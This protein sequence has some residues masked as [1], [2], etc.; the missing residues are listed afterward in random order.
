MLFNSYDFLLVFLPVAWIGW[1]LMRRFAGYLP[2]LAWLAFVS[3]AFYGYWSIDALV[4]MLASLSINCAIGRFIFD[5]RERSNEPTPEMRLLVALGIAG[6]LAL[7]GYFKYMGFFVANLNAATGLGLD[8]GAIVLPIGIS[9]YT[10]QQIAWLVDLYRGHAEKPDLLRHVLF[11][12]F[13]PH[14]I[15]GPITH[16]GEM[17][18]QFART[19]PGDKVEGM[20][21]GVTIGLTMFAIGL[22][23]KVIIA[24][25]IARVS[26]PIFLAAD[27]G[28]DIGLIE[29]WL[30]AIA[31][32]L[33]IYFDFSGYSDMAIG[34]A[35]MF[36]IILPLNFNSPYKA[37]SISDFWRRWH[38][39]L[40]R[41]LRDYVY[42]P[43]GGNR[44]GEWSKGRNLL[45]TM[46]LGGL[47][48]GA[49]WNFVIWGGLHGV[50]LIINQFWSKLTGRSKVFGPA[51]PVAR[52]AGQALTLLAVV[53]AWVFFRAGTLDGAFSILAGMAG[54]HGLPSPHAAIASLKE[55]K[56]ALLLLMALGAGIALFLPN[57]AELMGRYR[58]A[59][60]FK[61]GIARWWQWEP[62]LGA[63]LVTSVLLLAGLA[64]IGETATEFLYFQF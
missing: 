34:L 49:A 39:T 7:L 55:A 38:M 50:Y 62:S 27:Q 32:T 19:R 14:L 35:R 43:L 58:P 28:A 15:A 20:A 18:P 42:I 10:F 64:S 2:T 60:G 40:S 13:F 51:N 25:Q 16:H 3:L 33:Q 4:I 26:T 54:A 22:A 6:N 9:F 63:A 45:A 53:I 44:S 37:T 52:I 1:A 61:A 30:A 17:M 8:I 5:L 48:H 46:L 11:I 56:P 57:S 29:A 59:G 23:K 47:W 41:F 36:G 24:D 12:T 31:Y 21:E